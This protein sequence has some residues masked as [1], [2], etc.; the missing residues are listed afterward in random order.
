MRAKLHHSLEGEMH[1]LLAQ[2]AVN[3][4]SEMMKEQK[5]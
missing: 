2:H 1:D 4:F 5:I 3:T